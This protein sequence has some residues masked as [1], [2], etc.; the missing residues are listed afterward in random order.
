MPD[1]SSID[2]NFAIETNIKRDN[3]KFYDAKSAPFRLF[4]VVHDGECYR[5][6]PKSVAEETSSGVAFLSMKTAGGRIRFVTNSPYIL[7]KVQLPA[8][9][10]MNHMPLSGSSGFDLYISEDGREN[11][12]KSFIPS[13]SPEYEGVID[14]RETK[15]RLVTINFPLYNRVNEVYVGLDETSSVEAAP[16]YSVKA[17]MVFY[18]SSITQ[19]GCASRPGT[20]Y[21]AYISRRYDADYLN[22]GFSG[23]AKGEAAIREYIKDL[24]MSAFI[25]DYDY[26]APTEEDLKKT[27]RPMYEAVREAHPDIPIIIMPRP[28]RYPTA[29]AQCRTKI[30]KST[31]DY[32]IE[33]G[34]KNVYCISSEE[35]MMLADDNGTVDGVHPN[36]LGF[37]SIADALT[38]LMDKLFSVKH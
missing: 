22:L 1:I 30:V 16:D 23:N 34:D 35:L 8:L 26:N 29:A 4:G 10:R 25:L 13:D 11:Y 27:H 20:C 37:F 9:E 17:P 2:K 24:D 14:F 3:L 21:Q 5:R 36:D 6:V 33:N 19:G 38:K 31:Y 18:G 15:M 7:L 28:V 12:R 32:A